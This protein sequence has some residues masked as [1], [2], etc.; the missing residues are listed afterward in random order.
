MPWP[1]TYPDGQS[2]KCE[3]I[4]HATGWGGVPRNAL[5]SLPSL[6]DVC[7]CSGPYPVSYPGGQNDPEE[8]SRKHE[9]ILGL[10]VT[11]SA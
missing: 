9:M 10:T 4:H 8:Q 5:I 6:D 1:V 11:V 3:M 7:Y 2:S